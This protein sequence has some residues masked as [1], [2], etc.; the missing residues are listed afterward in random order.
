MQRAGSSLLLGSKHEFAAHNIHTALKSVSKAKK[1]GRGADLIAMQA[2]D[3]GSSHACAC[4]Q[5][6]E[7]FMQQQLYF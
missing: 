7:G 6:V 2:R 4:L 1:E 5:R 3:Q